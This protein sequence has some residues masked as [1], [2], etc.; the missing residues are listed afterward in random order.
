M[1]KQQILEQNLF[2]QENSGDR[3][4]MTQTTQMSSP[5]QDMTHNEDS[6]EI[7]D[8]NDSSASNMKIR[9]RLE[10]TE[11]VDQQ[12]NSI[13]INAGIGNFNI[14]NTDTNCKYPP[15]HSRCSL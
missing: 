1:E 3:V 8:R 12:N 6:L 7:S 14:E 4:L 10:S 9:A 5:T 15:A 13:E 11:K 2:Y